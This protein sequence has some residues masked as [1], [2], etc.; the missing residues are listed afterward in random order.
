MIW[1]WCPIFNDLW[2]ID[3]TVTG[4]RKKPPVEAQAQ[5]LPKKRINKSKKKSYKL[6]KPNP[7]STWLNSTKLNSKQL[8]VTRVEVRHSS[9][10]FHPNPAQPNPVKQLNLVERLKLFCQNP[11]TNTTRT[12]PNIDLWM[13][14]HK[15]RRRWGCCF[16]GYWNFEYNFKSQNK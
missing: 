13:V 8:Y 6:S 16:R 14:W 12:Q 5:A 15:G 4:M 9:Q 11:K 1:W 2:W 10:V 7:N 3:G